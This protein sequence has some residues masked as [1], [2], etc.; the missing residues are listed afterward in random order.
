MNCTPFVKVM[1]GP[2]CIDPVGPL[3]VTGLTQVQEP[4]GF[5]LKA[6]HGICCIMHPLQDE[7]LTMDRQN[8]KLTSLKGQGGGGV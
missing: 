6:S 4:S 5:F 1:P 2:I 7:K 3:M 8:D